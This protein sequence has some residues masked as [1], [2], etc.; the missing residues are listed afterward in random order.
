M[1]AGTRRGGQV[2][3][4]GSTKGRLYVTAPIKLSILTKGTLLIAVEFPRPLCSF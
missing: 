1:E 2:C 3:R 4:D